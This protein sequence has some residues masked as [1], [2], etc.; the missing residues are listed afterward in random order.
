MGFPGGSDGKESVCNARDQ[1]LIPGLGRFL[2]EGHGKATHSSILAWRTPWTEETGRIYSPWGR[3][4]SDK[5]EPLT[6]SLS[7]LVISVGFEEDLSE[8]C[9]QAI[10]FH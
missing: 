9:A 3:K 1:G 4:E 2:E 6:L 8:T 5:T 7:L 10:I